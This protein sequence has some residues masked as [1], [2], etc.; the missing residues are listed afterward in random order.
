LLSPIGGIGKHGSNGKIS[1]AVS[2]RIDAE[3]NKDA[4]K[5]GIGTKITEIAPSLFTVGKKNIKLPTV[6]DCPECNGYNRYDRPDRRFQNDDRRFNEPIRGK[7]SVHD[8]LGG[9]DLV[10]MTGLVNVLVIFQETKKSLKKWQMHG[11]R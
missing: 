3:R 8:R 11:T 1:I 2:K 9:A 10:C 7:M 6:R 5:S 4:D